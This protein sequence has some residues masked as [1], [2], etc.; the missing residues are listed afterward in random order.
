MN[1]DLDLPSSLQ[2]GA[3]DIS[4]GNVTTSPPASSSYLPL[5]RHQKQIRL[6]TI[7]LN[8]T[9]FNGVCSDTLRCRLET[10]LLTD[11]LEYECLSN[12]WGDAQPYTKIFLDDH[13]ISITRNAYNALCRF[14]DDHHNGV[15]QTHY[16]WIDALCINQD[17]L[18]ERAHQVSFM[19][20]IY[21]RASCVRAWL[22]MPEQPTPEYLAGTKDG[23]RVLEQIEAH[24]I[25]GQ[26]SQNVQYRHAVRS[27]TEVFRNPYWSRRWIVQEIA[28]AKALKLYHHGLP[29]YFLSVQALQALCLAAVANR[30]YSTDCQQ[31]SHPVHP[32]TADY[33]A[34]F[35]IVFGVIGMISTV[36]GMARHDDH[37][38]SLLGF[39]PAAWDVVP[40]YNKPW[41]ELFVE[42]TLKVIETGDSSFRIETDHASY[43]KLRALVIDTVTA[44]LTPNDEHKSSLSYRLRKWTQLYQEH[45]NAT[46]VNRTQNQQLPSQIARTMLSDEL[47]GLGTSSRLSAKQ[48]ELVVEGLC[49]YMASDEHSDEIMS[50][51]PPFDKARLM[52][53]KSIFFM[54]TK[55]RPSKT[56]GLTKV[57]DQVCVFASCNT[58][59]CVR[60]TTKGGEVVYRL[61]GECYVDVGVM[62]GEAVDE[63]LA[64]IREKLAGEGKHF[65]SH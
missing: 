57:G 36:Q 62:E 23:F 42:L 43:I 31:H 5:S 10:F 33:T 27:L 45:A 46:A 32:A 11:G 40:D 18:E 30:S 14:H 48:L 39:L 38:Y 56:A 13:A 22:A 2:A 50:F 47:F 53:E 9:A 60:P 34:D 21:R 64:T 37:V 55:S 41:E 8:A 58:P 54:T 49:Q 65:H 15:L 26:W 7:L 19:A 63:A 52:L 16:L 61:V 29:A 25:N 3:A 17:D 20:E 24:G 59:F 51:L 28:F 6:L 12:C 1:A 4:I 35:Q 44:V